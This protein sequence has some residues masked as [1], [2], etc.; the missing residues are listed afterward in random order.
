MPGHRRISTDLFLTLANDR[1][2]AWKVVALLE[3]DHD[4][5]P[6]GGRLSIS[7]YAKKWGVNRDTVRRLIAQ[8]EEHIVDLEV[9]L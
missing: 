7:A 3:L 4:D 5:R 6:G 1:A 9:D 8:Y 2:Q